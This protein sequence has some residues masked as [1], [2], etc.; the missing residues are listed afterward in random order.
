MD[1]GDNIEFM[2]NKITESLLREVMPQLDR[3]NIGVSILER[4][5][6]GVPGPRDSEGMKM[7]L[8]IS[9][10]DLV[11]TKHWLVGPC[12]GGDKVQYDFTSIEKD[13]YRISPDNLLSDGRAI[14]SYR[15]S[16]KNSPSFI[17]A[18]KSC[19]Y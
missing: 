18:T 17:F 5:N 1:L 19:S 13:G 3:M 2:Y 15:V 16:K 6:I 12:Y 4:L 14:P 10:C 7:P 11:N 8:M 9:S